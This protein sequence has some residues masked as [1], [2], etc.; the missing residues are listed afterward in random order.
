MR[1]SKRL[2]LYITLPALAASLAIGLSSLLAERQALTAEAQAQLSAVAKTRVDAIG[3]YLDGVESDLRYLA[4]APG[5]LRALEAFVFGWSTVD[6]DP[7]TT[8]QRLYI[9]ENPN[10]KGQKDLLVAADDGSTYSR[11]HAEHHPTFRRMLL[12]GGYYDVFLFDSRGNLVYSVYKESDYATN[13]NTGAYK[14]TDLG[15]AYRAAMKA[16]SAEQVS[17]FDFRPYAPSAGAPASFVSAPIMKDGAPVGALVFQMPIDRF[18]AVM[19]KGT[20]LGETGEAL[21]VGEDRLVRNDTRFT[22]GAILDRKI[23]NSAVT[24]A[25]AGESGVSRFGGEIVAFEP[26]SVRGVDYA[27][28]A[29][30]D[31][32]EALA[33]VDEAA[34]LTAGLIIVFAIACLGLG[35]FLGGRVSVPLVE[36]TQGMS[37][38]ADGDLAV[39]VPQTTRQDEIGDMAQAMLV[40]RE[41]GRER[42]RMLEA[43]RREQ[44]AK[45]SEAERKEKRAL[46]VIELTRIFE[47]KVG[48]LMGGLASGSEELERAAQ[49]MAAV[50]EETSGQAETVSAAATQTSANVQTVAASTE[51]M[52]SSIEEIGQQIARTSE[53]ADRTAERSKQASVRVETL[54]GEADRVG[55]VVQLISD[56][57]A[58][59]N[60]LALNATIEAARAGEA[61]KG[62]AVVA[63]EVKSLAE[64]TAKATDEI[65]DQIKAMQTGVAEAVPAIGAISES[66]EQL[67]EIATTVASAS[68]EQT[69]ATKEISRNVQEAAQGVDQVAGNVEGLREGAQST[70][71]AADQVTATAK[72]IAELSAQLNVSITDYVRD[73][74]EDDARAQGADL[75]L[76]A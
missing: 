22:E 38:L 57:A 56:I 40:F 23:D 47:Q 13:L 39:D 62:F 59:T 68:E 19:S 28:L 36:L 9:S 35:L 66:I 76:V 25:L 44:E 24:A 16:G 29:T 74:K 50:A 72:Q 46:E 51:E 63:Q 64:Q 5:T 70:A 10:P 48:E 41:N 11:A 30:K 75:K 55:Q 12:E 43:Q 18:N 42:E 7:K 67:T 54:R 20:G 58:Q 27:L 3:Q 26:L 2:T 1:L 32:D 65:A 69:T 61:G 21:L 71:S 14:E 53:I 31:A 17:Y 15:E 4:Q 73:M 49:Q 37:Q 45:A 34:L 33:R 52:V 60:L 6:G 8:L